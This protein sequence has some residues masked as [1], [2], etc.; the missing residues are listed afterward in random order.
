[1][2]KPIQEYVK[3]VEKLYYSGKATEHSY[4][5]ALQRLVEQYGDNIAVTNKPKRVKCGAPDYIITKKDIP[6]GYI[7]AKDVIDGILDKKETTAQV[8]RY[9][10]GGLGHNFILTD[11]LEFRF[12]REGKL[13]ETLRVAKPIGKTFFLDSGKYDYLGN[14]LSNFCQYQGQTITSSRKLAEMMA[15]KARMIQTVILNALQEE[16]DAGG[17]IRSQFE[18]FQNILMHDMTG[19]AVF[20]H[21]RPDN[22]L[23]LVCCP[24]A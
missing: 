3:D 6:I 8:K 13:V 2:T 20:R 7:E 10:N 24:S 12:Y 5:P 14:L 23:R 22:Y 17:E 11:Y 1:M 18:A 15:A 19:K 4:R 16:E 9:F 21:V